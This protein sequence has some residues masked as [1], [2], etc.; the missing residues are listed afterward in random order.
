MMFKKLV[1][2]TFSVG[3]WLR[4]F[5]VRLSLIIKSERHKDVDRP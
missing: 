4:K 5:T 1:R 2:F 3:A